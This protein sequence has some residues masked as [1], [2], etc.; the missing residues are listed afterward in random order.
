MLKQ[1]ETSGVHTWILCQ[2]PEIDNSGTARQFYLSRAFP[3]WNTAPDSS[4]TKQDHS[5]RQSV[6]NSALLESLSEKSELVDATSQF[7][8]DG[9][10]I[11]LHQNRAFY[12]DDDHLTRRGVDYFLR[13]TLESILGRIRENLESDQT[14]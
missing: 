9:N 4:L 13:P 1:L 11:P 12:R 3:K 14:R 2:I 6:A 10:S 5:Q 8:V 7:F